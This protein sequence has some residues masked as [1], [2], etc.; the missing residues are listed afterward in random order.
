MFKNHIGPSS[1]FL[2]PVTKLLLLELEIDLFLILTYKD[3]VYFLKRTEAQQAKNV[4]ATEKL[5]LKCITT[6]L[7]SIA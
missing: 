5:V 6:F 7:K 2:S 1:G 3:W 4:H